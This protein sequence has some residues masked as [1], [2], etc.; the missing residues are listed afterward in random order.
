MSPPSASTDSKT[1]DSSQTT[2]A[3][4]EEVSFDEVLE[5][6]DTDSQTCIP[7]PSTTKIRSK[8]VKAVN[9]LS[10]QPSNSHTCLSEEKQRKLTSNNKKPFR[11]GASQTNFDERKS[12][13]STLRSVYKR[14]KSFSAEQ[15]IF[16]VEDI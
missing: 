13:F 14:K 8:W 16:P 7:T 4:P 9:I 11:R 10:K 2:S 1:V 6:S 15:L 12:L 3:L 5:S